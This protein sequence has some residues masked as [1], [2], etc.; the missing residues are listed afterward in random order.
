MQ[1]HVTNICK[2]FVV[3]K[4]FETLTFKVLGLPN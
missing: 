2:L 4:F 1:L 3:G